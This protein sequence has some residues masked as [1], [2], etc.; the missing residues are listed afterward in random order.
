MICIISINNIIAN[1]IGILQA[2]EN[3]TIKIGIL[4]RKTQTTGINQNINTTNP[5][6]IRY[7]NHNHSKKI[8][9][10]INN[11]IIVNVAFTKAI[12]D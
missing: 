3:H 7:G 4:E 2:A 9:P 1:T 5:K 6:V 12:R 11:P 8:I 10:I